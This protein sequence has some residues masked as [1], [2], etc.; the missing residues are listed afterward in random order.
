MLVFD[1]SKYGIRTKAPQLKGKVT[2]K[3]PQASTTSKTMD[4]DDLHDMEIGSLMDRIKS[5]VVDDLVINS[6]EDGR[7]RQRLQRRQLDRLFGI[8]RKNHASF[9]VRMGMLRKERE[10]AA[11]QREQ[12][13]QEESVICKSKQLYR[14]IR[15]RREQRKQK[16]HSSAK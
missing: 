12:V 11:K 15:E 13:Q 3:K 4:Q 16:R 5:S 6:T 7:E 10:R 9:K 14:K 8:E 2:E 1:E